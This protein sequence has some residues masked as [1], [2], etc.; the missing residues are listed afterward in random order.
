MGAIFLGLDRGGVFCLTSIM[1]RK[2]RRHTA[3]SALRHTS[4]S[5]A[6][7]VF[8]IVVLAVLLAIVSKVVLTSLR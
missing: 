2:K 1:A 5:Q 8:V 4:F 3:R 7:S 6:E